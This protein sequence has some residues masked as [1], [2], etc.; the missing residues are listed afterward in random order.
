[1]VGQDYVEENLPRE[2]LFWHACMDTRAPS[3]RPVQMSAKPMQYLVCQLKEY[4]T[5]FVAVSCLKLGRFSNIF[6]LAIFGKCSAFNGL[7]SINGLVLLTV[8]RL[9]IKIK[10]LI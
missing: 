1:M 8:Y 2:L 9:P 3:P 7:K 6:T 4:S 5:K 10:W